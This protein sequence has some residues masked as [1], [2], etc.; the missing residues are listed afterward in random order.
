MADAKYRLYGRA[1]T[2]SDVV[3]MLLEDIAVP[4][5]FVAVGREPADIEAYRALTLTDKV[6][7]LILRHG[8]AMFESAAIC[9]HL[10]AAHPEGR[11]APA[12]GTADHARFLQWMVYLSANLYECARRIYYP[13][14][15]SREGENAAAG[16]RLQAIDDFMQILEVIVPALTPYVLGRDFSAADY[17]LYV[18]GGWHPDGREPV[19]ERWPAL[20]RHTAL[21][22]QR[23]A[24]RKVEADQAA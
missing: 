18:V 3:R 21:V 16:I 4:Y 14:R 13:Q 1:G 9:I 6:P 24:V 15:Y 20:A 22:A 19:H 11:L 17:Y 23:A 7:A 12:P 5:D 8:G 10:A 2:G